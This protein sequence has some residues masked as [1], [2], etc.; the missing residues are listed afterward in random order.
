V[1]GALSRDRPGQFRVAVIVV[2]VLA[3]SLSLG[4]STSTIVGTV[5]IAGAGA[6]AGSCL[7]GRLM[8]AAGP[9]AD[10]VASDAVA[11][12][13]VAFEDEPARTQLHRRSF[14]R[15]AA[16]AAVGVAVGAAVVGEARRAL[17]NGIE[18]VRA[19]VVLPRPAI[20]DPPVPAGAN[21]V[22]IAPAITPNADFYRVDTA[23][24]LPQVDTS[25]YT[26]SL[27]GLVAKPSSWSYAQLMAM[28]QVE[29]IVTLT[30]VSNGVGGD[31]VSNARWQGVPLRALLDL[32]GGPTSTAEQVLGQSADGF[33]AGFP[34]ELALDGREPFVAFAMNGE[35]LPVEHGFPARLV[36]PGLYGYVSATKWLTSITLTTLDDVGYWVGLG[37]SMDGRIIGASRIDRPKHDDTVPAGSV[38]VAGR[39]W[40]Q[41]VGVGGVQVQV[42]SEPW[43]DATLADGM[44]TNAW[45]LWSYPWAAVSGQHELK[46]RMIDPDGTVQSSLVRSVFPGA[47]S[48]L[49]TISV[50]VA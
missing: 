31:L 23:L 12:D 18:A 26:L 22:G 42:D 35:P 43:Q 3:G 13:T 46:V 37:W 27:G 7:Y 30:C 17:G 21:V 15:A 4:S 14:L 47:S 25:S 19:A 44:G 11:V 8:A 39:A 24:Y 20:S 36:V 45:R 41:H 38:V 32:A 28:P 48:G 50:T 34:L 33:T 5:L 40:H 2:A 10:A 9:V 16:L 29:R 6:V 1:L 49:D